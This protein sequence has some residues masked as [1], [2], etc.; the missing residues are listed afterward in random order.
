MSCDGV[1]ADGTAVAASA[2]G[3][4][5]AAQLPP[6][7][8]TLF[9]SHDRSGAARP[10]DDA[11][12]HFDE[13]AVSKLFIS[14]EAQTLITKVQRSL[15]D[16]PYE[17]FGRVEGSWNQYNLVFP[18]SFGSDRRK[19][20]S[21]LMMEYAE[22]I[23][24]PVIYSLLFGIGGWRQIR[25]HL[26]S[27]KANTIKVC[28]TTGDIDGA[29]IFHMHLDGRIGILQPRNYTQKHSSRLLFSVVPDAL[30][31]TDA[32][33]D[34]AH[35]SDSTSDEDVDDGEWE[36]QHSLH[37]AS[38]VQ[39]QSCSS[40]SDHRTVVVE[41]PSQGDYGSGHACLHDERSRYGCTVYP[42]WQR[43]EGFLNNHEVCHQRTF[44][45]SLERQ[46]LVCSNG[47][48]SGHENLCNVS[49]SFTGI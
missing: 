7:Q 1:C 15:V 9:T 33:A 40:V 45:A 5:T 6:S 32:E 46:R 10:I 3:P 49:I 35:A 12:M 18:S 16:Q 41:E 44:I 47:G 23:Y 2:S 30:R 37:M 48:D 42:I 26:L 38:L 4:A 36:R 17:K 8:R 43:R 27:F 13:L 20:V 22:A 31:S 29:N 39:A 19:P 11:H 28:E 24:C 25:K 14:R 21:A 34:G